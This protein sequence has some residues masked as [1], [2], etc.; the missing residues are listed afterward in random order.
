MQ[1][2]CDIVMKG[3]ITS[4][5]VYPLAAVELAGEHHFRNIGGTSAGAIAAAAVAAAEHGRRSGANPGAYVRIAGLPD[6]L[7]KDLPSL[8]QP[9]WRMRPFFDTI[10]SA[11]GGKLF[12][13]AALFNGFPLAALTGLLPGFALIV[14]ALA[15]QTDDGLHWPAIAAGVLLAPLGAIAAIA[16]SAALRLRGLPKSYYGICLGNDRRGNAKRPPLTRWLSELLNDL[17]GK[18]ATAPLTF[19]DL[20]KLDGPDKG[21]PGVVLQMITTCLTQGRPYS[22]PFEDDEEL[23]FC[24]DEFRDLFPKQVVDHMVAKARGAAIG[25]GGTALLRLPKAEDMPVVV[26][27]R[28]SLS[29]PLLIAAVPLYARNAHDDAGDAPE[30]CWFSDGGISSNMPIHFF[31]S[32]LPRWPTY[33]INLESLPRG[34]ESSTTESDNVW[35]PE[36]NEEGVGEAWIAAEDKPG[37]IP[38][39]R[40]FATI[41]RTA[42]NWVDNR[43]MKGVG[44]RDRIAHIRL[45]KS[46]G[47]MNLSMDAEQIKRLGD[48]GAHA[49]ERLAERFGPSPPAGTKLD[50]DNQRWL[51]FRAYLE[52]VERRG[53]KAVR[54][55]N[56]ERGAAPMEELNRRGPEKPPAFAWAEGAQRRFAVRES[57]RLLARFEAWE[58]NGQAFEDGAPGPRSEPWLI[59]RI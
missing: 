25:A 45:S 57:E 14:L 10:L 17:A 26:A 59:P 4:G 34:V 8:F 40:F 52:M 2:Y 21:E 24:E 42:Q 12:K 18:P 28:M 32:P 13:A 51:R 22:L 56:A 33:A 50:W 16:A 30:R 15:L 37:V 11:G 47:G 39:F 35:L 48:R 27:A 53:E 58:L 7:G 46:E 31:D 36:S 23:W 5:V 9:S 29:F 1:R 41:F 44:N 19:G 6:E 3:G 55:Y 38:T 49:A 43:Q 20:W 54:G